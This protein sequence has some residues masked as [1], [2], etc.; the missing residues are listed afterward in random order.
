MAQIFPEEWKQSKLILLQKGE[1]RIRSPAAYR[2]ISLLDTQ[3]KLYEHLI[4]NKLNEELDRTGGLSNYQFGFRKGRQTVGAIAEWLKKALEA[5][6]YAPNNR[7]LCAVITLDVRN[8]FNS[9]SWQIILDRLKKRGIE[10]RLMRLIASYLSDRKLI[11]EADNQVKTVE[12]NSGVPQG[13]VLG[14]TLWNILYDDLLETKMAE[15]TKLIGFADDLAMVVVAKTEEALMNTANTSLIRV[16]NWMKKNKLQLAPHKTEA[17]LLTTKRKISEIHFNLEDVEIK[18]SKTI[19]YLGVWLDTKMKFGEHIDKTVTKA[20]RTLAV[21]AST[22]KCR[23]T[24][25]F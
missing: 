23:W 8:A 5:A 6:D 9:A 16:L 14:P 24:K 19:R 7:K 2:P 10:K 11:L 22:S 12:I 21:L 3:G 4:L 18:L 1:S 13:S 20:S 17:I 25:S 15:G